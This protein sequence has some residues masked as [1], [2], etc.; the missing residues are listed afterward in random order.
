MVAKFGD[1][2]QTG[3]PI[4]YTK[5][6]FATDAS[7]AATAAAEGSNWSARAAAQSASNTAHRILPAQHGVGVIMP[8]G[9]PGGARL[10]QAARAARCRVSS[11]LGPLAFHQSQRFTAST[12]SSQQ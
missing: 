7:E 4:I 8:V 3:D 6:P 9:G 5:L 2:R 1:R 12:L 11:S 10:G